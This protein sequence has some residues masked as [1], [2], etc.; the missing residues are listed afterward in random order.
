MI[1]LNEW[2]VRPLTKAL[3]EYNKMVV[4]A[5]KD[6]RKSMPLLQEIQEKAE[7]VDNPEE[8]KKG[9]GANPAYSNVK[10]H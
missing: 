10:V 9:V 8:L 5:I 6:W 3:K 7:L 4:Q 1:V 2:L